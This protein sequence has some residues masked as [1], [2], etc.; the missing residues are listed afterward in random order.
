M[1]RGSNS[2]EAL[3][4]PN[5]LPAEQAVL[6][7]IIKVPDA[8]T[9]VRNILDENSWYS[10]R[11][12]L[13]YRAMTALADCGEPI[14]IMTVADELVK[15]GKIEEVGGRVYLV[16]LCESVISSANLTAH[17]KI[18]AEKATYRKI[19]QTC[20]EIAD[21]A[22]RQEM[23]PTELVAGLATAITSFGVGTDREPVRVG[24]VAPVVLDRI[25]KVQTGQQNAGLHTGFPDIDRRIGAIVPGNMVVIAGRP[26]MG[27][28]SFALNVCENLCKSNHAVAFFSAEESREE[29][30]LKLQCSLAR[31]DSLRAREPK[32]LTDDE[33]NRLTRAM[34][35]LQG[36]KLYIDDTPDIAMPVL[37]TKAALLKQQLGIDAVFVDYLQK[38]RLPNHRGKYNEKV[39]EVSSAFVRMVKELRVVGFA[40]SQLSADLESRPDKRPRLSDLSWSGQISQDTDVMI[41]LYRQELYCKKAEELQKVQ[42]QAE[43]LIRKARNGQVGTAYL[44]YQAEYT[45]F[46]SAPTMAQ[47]AQ[48]DIPF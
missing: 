27:K 45:R 37:T 13:I 2:V 19:R 35:E 46:E 7:A 39:M 14:D 17:A 48:E 21:S 3:P 9:S 42:G 47:R 15:C 31:V 16:E 38:I 12:R 29:I 4:E 5:D 11:H 24:V 8:L 22:S 28:T 44:T 26:S 6:G 32:C 10:P 41:G 40:L 23:E 18:V 30:T 25:G 1:W 33:W 34:A 36:W 20:L 43:A